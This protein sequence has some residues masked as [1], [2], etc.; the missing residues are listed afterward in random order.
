MICAH[1]AEARFLEKLSE[2]IPVRL[3]I[4]LY[5]GDARFAMDRFEAYIT[6]MHHRLTNMVRSIRGFGDRESR[7]VLLR[8]S[9][10]GEALYER[11]TRG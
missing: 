4:L 10:I 8:L 11:R 5:R 2:D 3:E 6:T 1:M 7:I 9:I